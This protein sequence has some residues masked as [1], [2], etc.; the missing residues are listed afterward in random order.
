[1][2]VVVVELLSERS[3]SAKMCI[4]R[5]K[6]SPLNEKSAA[7]SGAASSVATASSAS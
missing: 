3:V 6:S 5:I 4:N 1:M 2:V 7:V